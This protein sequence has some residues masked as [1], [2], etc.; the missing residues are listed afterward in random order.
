MADINL[1]GTDNSNYNF[2]KTGASLAVKIL[3][4]LLVL[5]LLYYGY[6][7][8]QVSR[9]ENS[10][11]DMQAK[12]SQVE[13]DALGR[14]ER[15]EV[16]TRQAQLQNLDSLIKNHL[17]WSGML[18]QLAR[19]TLKSASYAGLNADTNGTLSLDVIVPNY[20]E[21]DKYIQVFDL[22]EFNQQFSDVKV[23]S[24]NKIQQ[25]STVQVELKLQLK[26]NPDFIRKS[27]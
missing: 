4:G 14:P 20:A 1:L 5:V 10:I 16:V 18:P 22:P 27:L 3:V 24:I 17:Y 8:W 2:A 9:T 13:A 21:A 26:F 12:T 7:R 25:G 23:L 15:G 6:L 19:V 11:R